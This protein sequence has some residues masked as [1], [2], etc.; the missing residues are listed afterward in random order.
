MLHLLTIVER[1]KTSIQDLLTDSLNQ[2][3]LRV[4][5]VTFLVELAILMS[6]VFTLQLAGRT[7]GTVGFGEYSVARRAMNVI[8]FPLLFGLGISIPRYVA[9][10][11]SDSKYKGRSPISYL[12]AGLLLSIPVV[13]LF[14]LLALSFPVSFSKLFFGESTY[15]HFALPIVL[16]SVGLYLQTL[17]YGYLRG[18]L[19]MRLANLFHLLTTG[20]IPPTA[21]LI[22]NGSA[23]R[24]LV[25]MGWGWIA[26]SILF[27]AKL[28]MEQRPEPLSWLLLPRR[29][30]ELFLYGIPRVPGEFALFGLFSV[31]TFLVSHKSGVEV[32]GFFS[33]GISLLSLVGAIFATLGILL[34]PYVSR[35]R[36][37][38]KWRSI[39]VLVSRALLGA[40]VVV[41]SM[42]VV[43]Q[44]A[45]S[46]IVPLWMGGSFSESI[47]ISRW[48]LWGAIP[49]A[50]Y[51]VLRNPIDAVTTRP[52][53]S[54]NLSIVFVLSVTLI[55]L[56]GSILPPQSA[57][58]LALGLLSIL[59]LFSWYRALTTEQ[60]RL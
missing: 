51:V 34:L 8:T 52:Y 39:R 6:G 1:G 10:C 14:G 11:D 17:V 21:V 57:M 56:G 32:A 24:S 3:R 37:E 25:F 58:F 22:S 44:L 60:V 55:W 35:L 45:L 41:V 19:A 49:Y 13:T 23:F 2:R 16:I 26:I 27:G 28:F 46:M 33:F 40:V 42:V 7:L 9:F 38:L 59:T 50:V 12:L 43:L 53:N 31:P 54:V 18:L 5:G 15:A 48:L 20:V 30:R 47:A 29:A 36:A 4:G